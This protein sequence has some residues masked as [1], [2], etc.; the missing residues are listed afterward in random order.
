MKMAFHLSGSA[1]C[2][3]YAFLGGADPAAARC[4]AA[5]RRVALCG[6]GR[7]HRR[8]HLERATRS[9]SPITSEPVPPDSGISRACV[10]QSLNHWPTRVR[11]RRLSDDR[12]PGPQTS[13]MVIIFQQIFTI[14]DKALDVEVEIGA[15]SQ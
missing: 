15:A 6:V 7:R 10:A 11:V 13:G 5:E 9:A 4:G 3:A 8:P 2:R 14:A 1:V 12:Q